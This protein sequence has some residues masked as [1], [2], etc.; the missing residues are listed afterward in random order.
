MLINIYKTLFNPYLQ[1][2]LMSEKNIINVGNQVEGLA[3][4]RS[5][6]IISA[7]FQLMTKVSLCLIL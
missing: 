2:K 5:K 3:H 4:S 6:F 7:L 1:E